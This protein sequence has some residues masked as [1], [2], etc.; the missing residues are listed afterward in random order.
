MKKAA[1]YAATIAVFM[2]AGAIAQAQ[3]FPNQTI[4]IIVPAAPGG[5]LDIVARAMSDKMGV[6]L[7]QS[8]I[9]ENRAGAGGNIGADFV[10]K[11]APDGYT[12]LL[13]LGSTLT[14]NPAIYKDLKFDLKPISILVSA[15]QMLVVHPSVPAKTVA[16]YVEWAKKEQPIAYGHAGNGTPAHLVMEYFRLRAGFKTTPVAYRGSAPLIT[17]LL[18]G[19]FK[20]AFGATVGLIPQVEDGRLRA[21]A[22]SSDVRSPLAPNVPTIAESGY[23]GFR[24]ESD[25]ILLAPG[26]TPDAIIST[27]EKA[28][29]KELKEPDIIESFRKQDLRIVGSTP[30]FAA[31]RIVDETASWA[32]IIKEIGLKASE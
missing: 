31:K 7:K 14:I 29:Q 5:P 27:L 8:V 30:E 32:G 13:S 3:P 10:S 9:V 18:S 1:I 19:Q 16:E 28:A 6:T 26:Q 11:S 20:T 2:S 25:F 22:I 17:D 23:P 4:K 21:I 12:L 15:T 24:L